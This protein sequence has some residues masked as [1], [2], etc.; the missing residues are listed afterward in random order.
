MTP[1]KY[2]ELKEDIQ[3]NGLLFPIILFEDQVLDGWHRYLVCTELGIEVKT[4][5]YGGDCPAGFVMSACNRRDMTAGQRAILGVEILPYLE[6]EAKKRKS[7]KHIDTHPLTPSKGLTPNERTSAHKAARIV[8]SSRESVKFIKKLKTED[9]EIY[10]KV[11]SGGYNINDAK[12]NLRAK[13]QAAKNAAIVFNASESPELPVGK[14][15]VLVIDPPWP[16]EKIERDCR[17]NQPVMLD[18]PVMT[19]EEI[20][21]LPLVTDFASDNCHMFLWTT[22]RFLPM[23]F[24]IFQSW[25]VKYVCTMTWHK[26]GGFQVC[27]LPQYNSEFILY[28]R[29]GSPSFVTTKAFNTCFNAPRGKHSEKPVEFYELLNRVTIGR[30][31]DCFNRRKIDGFVGWGNE[32]KV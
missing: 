27:G 11:K 20:K 18:Y 22:H 10:E 4:E 19:I 16:I 8:K 12:R 3:K 29:I 26:P 21:A 23:A 24:E 25:D 30:R 2:S 32:A 7:D 17:P 1:E 15:D 31:L 6:A 5:N 9:P 28:G 14:F 13:K